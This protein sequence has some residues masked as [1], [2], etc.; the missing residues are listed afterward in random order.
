M[1]SYRIVVLAGDGVGPEIIAEGLKV[2]R[3]AMEGVSLEAQFTELEIGAARYR[4]TG[5]AFGQEDIEK[6]RKA[7]AVY[8]GAVGLP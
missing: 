6:V 7:D 8:F 2:I 3:A 4:R 1:A 5:A